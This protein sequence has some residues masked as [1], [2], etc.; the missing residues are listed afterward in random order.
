MVFENSVFFNLIK[1]VFK[2]LRLTREY[3]GFGIFKALPWS[4]GDPMVFVETLSVLKLTHNADKVDLCIIY[5]K[6]NPV[7]N[8]GSV[9]GA[10]KTSMWGKYKS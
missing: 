1:L 7:G 6:D 2:P 4:V 5:D 10:K 9:F 3:L 8:R